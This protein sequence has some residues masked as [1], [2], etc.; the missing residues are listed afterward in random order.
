VL[1]A[2][3]RLGGRILTYRGFAGAMYGEFGAMR[4]PAQHHLVRHL[5]TERFK[6]ETKPFP[7]EADNLVFLQG[8]SVRNSEF[9]S[10]KF[11]FSSATMSARRRRRRSFATPSG[12]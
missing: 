8:K 6:L 3:D 4:F 7:M 9:D 2:Q 11:D 10:T 1:E 5:I 12:P